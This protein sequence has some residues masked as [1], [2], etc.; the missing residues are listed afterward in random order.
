MQNK[1]PF[2]SWQ[3]PPATTKAKKKMLKA[4]RKKPKTQ[5]GKLIWHPSCDNKAGNYFI[6]VPC[7]KQFNFSPLYLQKHVPQGMARKKT[8]IKSRESR[9]KAF[10]LRLFTEKFLISCGKQSHIT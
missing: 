4:S 9:A 10:A 2:F 6:R 1:F 3:E 5:K 8:T 7:L